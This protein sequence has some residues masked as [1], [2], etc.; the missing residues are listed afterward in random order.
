MEV[1]PLWTEYDWGS[2]S[3]SGHLVGTLRKESGWEENEC[4]TKFLEHGSKEMGM[5]SLGKNRRGGNESCLKCMTSWIKA[6][7]G[8]F[9]MILRLEL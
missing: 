3:M 8:L 5:F 2:T 9:F 6:E 4:Q 7:L 1:L